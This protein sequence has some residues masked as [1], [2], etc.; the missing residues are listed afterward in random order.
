MVGVRAQDRVE[1][2]TNDIERLAPLLGKKIAN[3]LEIAYL[4]G[5]EDYR[6]KIQE[7]ID[8]IKAAVYS[9]E[10]LKDSVLIQP[11]PKESAM[12]GDFELGSILYG[13]KE[14]Y[15]L[16]LNQKDLLTHIGIFGSSGSGKTNII[17]YLIQ[18]LNRLDVPVL[19]FDFSKRNYRDLLEIPELRERIKIYTVG[20]NITPFR[21]N[22]LKPPE[23]VQISQWAKE[24]AEVFDHAYWMMGGGRHVVLKALGELYKKFEPTLPRIS[25]LKNWMERYILNVNSAR[26]KN[27]VATASRPLESLSFRETGEIFDCDEGLNPEKFF[28]KGAITIL[29]LDALSND[30][31]T[32][33][34]EILLQ[35]VRDWLIVKNLRE[36][37]VG[38]IVLEEAHHVLNREKTKKFGMETVTDLIFR[39][40]R[41]LG[42]G[43]IYVD[44]HPSLVS[45]PALGNTSTHIYMNLGLDTKYSSDIEDSA[46]M[47]GLTELKDID[48]LRRLPIGHAFI[49]IRKS[50]FPN[51]FLIKFPLVLPEKGNVTDEKIRDVMGKYLVKEIAKREEVDME[52]VSVLANKP[53][54][55]SRMNKID[56]NGWKIIETLA[57]CDAVATS[58]IYKN[59]KMSGKTFD[60]HVKWLVDLGFVSSK[61]AKVYKQNAVFHFLT[62]DGEL[63]YI[64][65]TGNLPKKEEPVDEEVKNF[66][67]Q[68]LTL[69][70][71][72]LVERGANNFVIFEKDYKRIIVNLENDYK[73]NKVYEDISKSGFDAEQYFVCS[74]E[75]VKNKVIQQA[76]KYSFEH[77]GL[78]LLIFVA[79]VDELKQGNDFRK[80][81]FLVG[82]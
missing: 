56:F 38:A 33:F 70:G 25:D 23:G 81:E 63:A 73:S 21:F 43:M 27:W 68:N 15:P 3:K 12:N 29:E 46:N 36:K 65:K 59:L 6:N 5:D 39:E 20:R 32:F 9:D 35:W 44:Q 19:V 42:I 7:I 52:R 72:L 66:V 8:A 10:D 67:I 30:D 34:I 75:R 55:E 18:V 1:N 57:N 78:N 41:E 24:F 71:W 69:K 37:V 11:P 53:A 50:V 64:L 40:I 77:R 26:E 61:K 82:S 16:F 31:K 47:L 62:H 60:K 48:Y 74:D 58:E 76:A 51:P 28:E 2:V 54:L 80:I 13:K 79:T 22:P 45:Y 4:L 17:H 49:L 14:M